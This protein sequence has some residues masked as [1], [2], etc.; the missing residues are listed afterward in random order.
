MEF[1]HREELHVSDPNSFFEDV[2]GLARRAGVENKIL[3]PVESKNTSAGL[4]YHISVKDKN[5]RPLGV[6]LNKLFFVTR[7]NM[8]NLAD[9]RE[10]PLDVKKEEN[11]DYIYK[12]NAQGRGLIRLH[13][14][15]R[16][17]VKTHVMPLEDELRF[18]LP[19]LS[20]DS[21][22]AVS[23]VANEIRKK[24]S[25]YVV[26]K[27]GEYQVEYL[28]DFTAY[29][30][31]AQLERVQ[32]RLEARKYVVEARERH[33]ASG[34]LPDDFMKRAPQLM[35]SED[36]VIF[37]NTM[38]LI[39][40]QSTLSE[41]IW[42]RI[43]ALMTSHI[44]KTRQYVASVLGHHTT[45]PEKVWRQLP[46]M[47]KLYEGSKLHYLFQSIAKQKVWPKEFWDHIP[48]Y[49]TSKDEYLSQYMVGALDDHPE[50]PQ[51]LLD[52]V[53]ELKA[54]MLSVTRRDFE[55]TLEKHLN[56]RAGHCML[57][58]VSRGLNQH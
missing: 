45:W 38:E 22:D 58:L 26:E 31:P 48:E 42:D 8:R 41:E 33:L 39:E 56:S 30:T 46:Q 1:R 18:I 4:H 10:N 32:P 54:K 52:R 35:T 21:K 28:K 44:G 47:I 5:L 50:W 7:V 51:D 57:Q 11:R 27:I 29:M 20:L 25:D 23:I 24:M 13:G 34:E 6:E 16:F 40:V 55:T 14:K 2:L 49:L 53:D 9:L 19:L 37:N 43:S 15:D 12:P 3:N 17:E 36:A